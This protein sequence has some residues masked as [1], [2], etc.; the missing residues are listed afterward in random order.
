MVTVHPEGMVGSE[1]NRTKM[2]RAAPDCGVTT[3]KVALPPAALVGLPWST[4]ESAVAV[5]VPL[6]G[7][8]Q[9]V[10]AVLAWFPVDPVVPVK[11]RSPAAAPGR[12]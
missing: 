3:R 7:T 12:R 9:K 1:S 8:P 10:A 5:T 2:R 6:L 4:T 11:A